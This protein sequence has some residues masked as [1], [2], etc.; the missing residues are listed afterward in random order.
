VTS[1][2]GAID[3][4]QQRPDRYRDAQIEP[5]P[6]FVP[7]PSVHADLA[8]A[9][10][11]ATAHEH[12]AAPMIEVSLGKRERLLDAQPR[13]PEDD[14]QA[15]SRRPCALSPAA[16]ITAMISSIVGGSAGYL[17]PLFCGDLPA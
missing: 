6:K 3:D 4:A 12:G 9:S 17:S 15:R 13:A 1:S 7:S 10:S 11:L 2:C 14:D 5:R 8:S 16:C